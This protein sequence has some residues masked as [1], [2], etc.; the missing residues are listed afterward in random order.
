MNTLPGVSVGTTDEANKIIGRK[1]RLLRCASGEE[2]QTIA[3]FAGI[4][5]RDLQEIE[6]GRK[7]CPLPCLIKIAQRYD[8]P[9]GDMTSPRSI[10]S[11]CQDVKSEPV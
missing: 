10:P 7:A 6:A 3:Q 4:D 5:Q 1:I 9:L 11:I 2:L 8:V